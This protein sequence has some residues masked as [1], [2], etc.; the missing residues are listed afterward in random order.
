MGVMKRL[1]R[2]RQQLRELVDS[3]RPT[4]PW[5]SKMKAFLLDEVDDCFKLDG[6]VGGEPLVSFVQRSQW[7]ILALGQ[8]KDEA[9]QEACFGNR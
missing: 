8:L 7:L 2:E 9:E 6:S 3:I 1:S 5:Q 4:T